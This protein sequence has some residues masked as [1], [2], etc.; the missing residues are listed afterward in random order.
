MNSNL[1]IVAHERPATVHTLVT[2]LTAVGY[3][4]AGALTFR[5]AVALLRDCRPALL[6]TNVTL[7]AHSGL[8]LVLRA[9]AESPDMKLVVMGPAN[10]EVEDKALALGASSY[11]RYPASP[12]V[13]VDHALSALAS[14][15][16]QA[17]TR[18]TVANAS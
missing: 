13:V 6:V 8:R 16:P 7:G 18:V 10:A 12:E 3:Q 1:I 9:A 11:V 15:V 14:P 2:A 4:A 5:D 17:R